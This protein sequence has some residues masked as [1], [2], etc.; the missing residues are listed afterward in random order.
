MASSQLGSRFSFFRFP[1]YRIL[2]VVKYLLAVVGIPPAL[3]QTIGAQIGDRIFAVSTGFSV[4]ALGPLTPRRIARRDVRPTENQ[5]TSHAC[6]W[7]R[8][9]V[10]RRDRY[11]CR[12]CDKK[13]DEITL[14]VC[15]I[16]PLGSHVE[17][18]VTLCAS[19]QSLLEIL[20]L[21]ERLNAVF[22]FRRGKKTKY[23]AA[24]GGSS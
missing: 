19:C 17:A 18:S 10:L 8:M 2:P 11:R 6:P 16:R 22:V 7:L 4:G 20:R 24:F 21:N 12:A 3:L 23:Y 14:R 13:G 15:P 5:D 9:R 1:S